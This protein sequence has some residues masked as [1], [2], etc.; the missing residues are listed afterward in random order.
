[1]KSSV[2]MCTVWSK[3][4]SLAASLGRMGLDFRSLVVDF[5]IKI[6]LERFSS[7]VRLATNN[8]LNEAK[9][10]SVASGELSSL[11][12]ESEATDNSKPPQPSPEVSMWDDICVYGNA[13]LEALNSLRYSPSP[14][15]ESFTELNINELIASCHGCERIRAVLDEITRE[16]VIPDFDAATVPKEDSTQAD[17]NDTVE[18][19]P[20]AFSDTSMC[21]PSGN[22][23][24]IH[25]EV[26]DDE[27]E[28]P[29][30]KIESAAIGNDSN[31]RTEMKPQAT[32]VP[33]IVAASDDVPA[34]VDTA[35]S[36]TYN[37]TED[38]PGEDSEWG[39]GQETIEDDKPPLKLKEK[40]S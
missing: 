37:D 34:L 30:I 14:M 15:L 21:S 9:V 12:M 18:N 28:S 17:T 13:I 36:P 26:G 5:L 19:V 2:D 4:M 22:P 39:W 6:V 38:V 20:S 40:S 16:R 35:P 7:A 10:L 1:M 32:D 33:L 29:D 11:S 25:F 23:S 31:S 3:L 8:F 24:S 27:D